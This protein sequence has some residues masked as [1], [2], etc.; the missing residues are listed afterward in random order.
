M[1]HVYRDTP[2]DV[3]P[4]QYTQHATVTASS[5]R[6]EEERR[7]T[8]VLH[9]RQQSIR[10]ALMPNFSVSGSGHRVRIWCVS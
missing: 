7:N 3:P 1:N 6:Y 5:G 2:G 10:S 9:R 8:D 4:R